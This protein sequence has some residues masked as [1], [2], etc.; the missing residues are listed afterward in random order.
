MSK[1]ITAYDYTIVHTYRR[2]TLFDKHKRLALR[3]ATEDS[4]IYTRFEVEI[5]IAHDS[6]GTCHVRLFTLVFL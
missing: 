2:T 1:A 4:M 6:S 5:S 3:N